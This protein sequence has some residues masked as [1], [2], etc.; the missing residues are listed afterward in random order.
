MSFL[1]RALLIVP[2][3]SGCSTGGDGV[4][5]KYTNW[6]HGSIGVCN[7][8][9]GFFG[10]DCSRRMCPKSDDPVTINQNS[11]QVMIRLNGDGHS[12]SG[13]LK[14]SLLGYTSEFNLNAQQTTAY[15]KQQWEKLENVETVSCLVSEGNPHASALEGRNATWNVTF[16]KFPIHP[17]ENNFFSHTGNPPLSAFTCDISEV[18]VNGG[19]SKNCVI[20]DLVNTDIKEY[21]FCSRRGT[22]DF[23]S[24]QCYC[25]SGYGGL[26]CS[27][28][29]YSI[30]N[31]NSEPA[32]GATATGNDYLGNVLELQ[33][34]KGASSDF[35]F[36]SAK[37]DGT[38]VFSISG[39][40]QIAIGE[41]RV[42]QTGATI[43]NGGLIVSSGG[44][45]ISNDGLRVT[46]A[47]G[48]ANSLQIDAPNNAFSKAVVA[49]YSANVASKSNFNLIEAGTS[50]AALVFKVRG[51]GKTIIGGGGLDVSG[52]ATVTAGGL[53]VT[54]GG[55]TITTDDA[56]AD[57]ALDVR[58]GAYI[59]NTRAN[60]TAL[61]VHATND[62]YNGT[63]FLVKSD[64]ASGTGYKDL[65]KAIIN[66]DGDNAQNAQTIFRVT[67]K[68]S[69][70]IERGG[71][72]VR[73]GGATV[74]AGGLVVTAAG[75][76]ITSGGLKVSAGGLDVQGQTLDFTGSTINGGITSS[77]TTTITGAAYVTG[78]VLTAD[79][80]VASSGTTS[81]TGAAYL[82][83][84][85]SITGAATASGGFTSSAATS[86]TGA[87]TTDG[88]VT[89]TDAVTASGGFTS[90]SVTTITGAAYVTGV[91]LTANGGITS[92]GTTSLT[93]AAY[94]DGANTLAGLT[95]TAIITGTGIQA[96]AT[97][98]GATMYAATTQLTSDRRFKGDI[99][100]LSDGL[101]SI[102][103]LQG[104]QYKWK[105][106]EFPER[107]FDNST[108]TGFIAQEVEKVLPNIVTTGLDGYKSINYNEVIPTLVEAL[109]EQQRIIEGLTERT[110]ALEDTMERLTD[111]IERDV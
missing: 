94:L 75:Q 79:S 81:L 23:S 28:T 25:F 61:T 53:Q 35:K 4:G 55:A 40:G 11:R 6:D 10:P 84:T 90:S 111:Q 91:A 86:I 44:V 5:P 51:D 12:F 74:N 46:N 42:T 8:D 21:E 9:P 107:G 34:E 80:G 48:G 1:F 99:R 60:A 93:G 65:I 71:F 37:A 45:T 69:F 97:I 26:D 98:T 88:T 19:S 85:T 15:C 70:R 38:E 68:P 101:L 17:M 54:G 62:A 106:G 30:S 100:E 56:A 31:A 16:D 58:E 105:R 83:G 41:L 92:S 89:M 27:S 18:V 7:C 63:A 76:T 102:T 22:C 104:V 108:H 14:V 32:L 96:S 24:G 82:D 39:E 73:S 36:L 67:S 29:A 13:K 43:E 64:A 49:A 110:K 2:S 78:V 95:A 3:F 66:S 72:H 20:K 52:G 33:T 109:K 59:K 47:L 87:L 77:G 50:S 103:Q 57:Y